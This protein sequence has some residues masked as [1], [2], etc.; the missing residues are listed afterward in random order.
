[1]SEFLSN[2]ISI[3]RLK[4]LKISHLFWTKEEMR[5]SIDWMHSSNKFVARFLQLCNPFLSKIKRIFHTSIKWR[6]MYAN[7]QRSNFGFESEEGNFH[8]L[9]LLFFVN[10]R[11]FA[12]GFL[13]HC[14]GFLLCVFFFQVLFWSSEWT[15]MRKECI[16]QWKLF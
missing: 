6:S 9:I 13:I 16:H 5:Q 3:K 14:L 8:Y 10:V 11:F 12:I 2:L 4:H 7:H 1:M 15:L